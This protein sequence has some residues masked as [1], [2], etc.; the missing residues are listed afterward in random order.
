MPK[1]DTV[2]LMQAELADMMAV[3]KRRQIWLL[4]GWQD[5]SIRYRRSMLG[6]FWI[7]LTMAVF[8]LSL[9][10]IYS[11]IFNQPFKDYLGYLACGLLAWNFLSAMISEATTIVTDGEAHLRNIPLPV[12]ILAARMVYRNLVIF[13]HNLLAILIVLMVFGVSFGWTLLVVPLS[14][15]LYA[16][17]GLFA[18]IVLGPI[19]A[20]FRDVPQVITNVVQILFFVTPI[21]W[22]QSAAPGRPII[23]D[24]NPF[25]DLVMLIRE[26]LQG[27]L[28]TLRHVLVATGMVAAM[29]VAAMATLSFV[30]KRLYLWL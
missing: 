8:V 3:Y 9:A 24:A 12:S 15:G 4:M 26:P 21:I 10:Y 14:V 5:I 13:A 29:G 11:E 6:P 7:S 17:F 22:M 25:N 28:P 1:L 20:R 18:G 19:C 27:R 16:L 30:R 2:E 23:V